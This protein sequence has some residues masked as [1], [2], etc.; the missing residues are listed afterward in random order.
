MIQI[1]HP[2]ANQVIVRFNGGGEVLFSYGTPVAGFIP[3]QGYVRT[4]ENHS[5]TTNGHIRGYLPDP[6]L[7]KYKELPQSEMNDLFRR[8][9]LQD[10]HAYLSEHV[11]KVK[12]A[13][14][15]S[16]VHARVVHAVDAL[17]RAIGEDS[18]LGPLTPPTEG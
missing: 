7:K 4:A 17:M 2:G 1:K 10:S 14:M 5:R 15:M 8:I 18:I 9:V 11:Q 12:D 3:G 13:T 6:G 16:N